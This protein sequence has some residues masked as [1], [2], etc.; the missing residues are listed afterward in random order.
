MINLELHTV[1]TLEVSKNQLLE[2][3]NALSEI[4]GAQEQIELE[5]DSLTN[6]H[7]WTEADLL[8]CLVY[9]RQVN[10]EAF[11]KVIQELL[12]INKQA[13]NIELVRK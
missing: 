9:I 4:N 1:E 12:P 10:S 11:N 7:Y 3:I 8:E 13:V 2:V 6:I 5:F